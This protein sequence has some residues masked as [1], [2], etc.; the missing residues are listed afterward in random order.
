MHFLVA[1][2]KGDHRNQGHENQKVKM[3]R[4]R[5]FLFHLEVGRMF[6][7]DLITYSVMLI[8]MFLVYCILGNVVSTNIFA[9]NQSPVI[10]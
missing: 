9:R 8:R 10:D 3:T 1:F 2:Y 5:P 7:T 6:K 4:M